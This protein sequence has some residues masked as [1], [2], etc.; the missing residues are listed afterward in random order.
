MLLPPPS[1]PLTLLSLPSA[2]TVIPRVGLTL[3]D[4]PSNTGITCQGRGCGENPITSWR[5]GKD[6]E[7][8]DYRLR[9]DVGCLAEYKTRVY[10]HLTNMDTAQ[11][12]AGRDIN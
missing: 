7:S 1:S 11:K 5:H 8:N 9:G 4:V 10:R 12:L 6:L 2:K 3:E